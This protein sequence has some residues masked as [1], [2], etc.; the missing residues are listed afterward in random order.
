MEIQNIKGGCTGTSGWLRDR[1]AE[2]RMGSGLGRSRSAAQRLWPGG[3][4]V[5]KCSRCSVSWANNPHQR[6]SNS[7][8]LG[9]LDQLQTFSRKTSKLH[10]LRCTTCSSCKFKSTCTHMTLQM[11]A[12]VPRPVS[13]FLATE[14]W[15]LSGHFTNCANLSTHIPPQGQHLAQDGAGRTL[16]AQSCNGSCRGCVDCSAWNGRFVLDREEALRSD[17]VKSEVVKKNLLGEAPHCALGW[18]YCQISGVDWEK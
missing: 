5:P 11:H 15:L 1:T 6:V 18:W 8:G 3:I 14:L 2:Q 9:P 10:T 12:R 13:G 16:H 4:V 17:P 7:L